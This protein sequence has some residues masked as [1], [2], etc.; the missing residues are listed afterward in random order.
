LS[1][2][3]VPSTALRPL[4]SVMIPAYNCAG[5][6]EQTLE[7]VLRQDPGPESME[8]EVVDDASTGDEVERVVRA[9][10]GSRVRYFRQP[11]NLGHVGNFNTCLMRSQGLLVHLLH[12]DDYVLPGFYR[13]MAE[14][15]QKNPEIG[16]AFC[17]YEAVDDSG[18]RVSLAAL[19]QAQ[20]GRIDGWLEKIARG[21]RLQPPAMV[22]RRDVYERLGGFD[23]RIRSYGEDWEM[24]V[25]IAAHYPVWYHPQTLAAYRV[26]PRSLTARAARTG[27]HAA[28]YRDVIRINRAHLPAAQADEWSRAAM[29]NFAGA[30]M[31]RGWRALGHGDRVQAWAHFRQAVRTS[32]SW[33]VLLEF[34]KGGLR[35]AARL[36]MSPLRTFLKRP[37]A[38]SSR[39]R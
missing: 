1:I 33:P 10:G 30:C 34:T 16:A 37:L 26:H 5:T 28:D 21:Q 38:R 8:I 31:R 32:R 2:P 39:S 19:E 35:A 13:A 12:G 15:F 24:W 9:R 27:A 7:S 11:V 20:P 23:A 4:W 6:L 17:R 29:R 3:P 36:V 22:V 25:R 18:H 14:P